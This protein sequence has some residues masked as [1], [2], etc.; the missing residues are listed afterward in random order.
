MNALS[1]KVSECGPGLFPNRLLWL[2]ASARAVPLRGSGCRNLALRAFAN[3]PP[4]TSI[5]RN[6]PNTYPSKLVSNP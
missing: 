3:K 4:Q 2:G 1:G 6:P 5:A